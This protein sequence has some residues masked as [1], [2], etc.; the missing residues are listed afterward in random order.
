MAN[1]GDLCIRV[2]ILAS[3]AHLFVRVESRYGSE[4]GRKLAND[5]RQKEIGR[6][7]R[8][9]LRVNDIAPIDHRRVATSRQVNQLLVSGEPIR[10]QLDGISL[11]VQMSCM[12]AVHSLRLLQYLMPQL[13]VEL[14]PVPWPCGCVHVLAPRHLLSHSHTPKLSQLRTATPPPTL[15]PDKHTTATCV[16]VFLCIWAPSAY[17]S[18]S[19]D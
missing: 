5:F 11:T 17:A 15:V 8:G 9:A 12:C 16:C 2:P 10:A 13:L 14:G 7:V 1:P 3:C 6:H 18:V 4:R 19:L